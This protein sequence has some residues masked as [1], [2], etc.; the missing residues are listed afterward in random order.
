MISQR[1]EQTGSHTAGEWTQEEQGPLH[2]VEWVI[3][4]F[5]AKHPAGRS[6]IM[7]GSREL[8]PHYLLKANGHP[9]TNT[10]ILS[11][12]IFKII[13]S[14]IEVKRGLTSFGHFR[15]ATSMKCIKPQ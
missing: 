14:F 13:S 5:I 12:H 7:T 10:L 9:K 3:A 4:A 1:E 15:M 8:S 2:V 11:L 6:P